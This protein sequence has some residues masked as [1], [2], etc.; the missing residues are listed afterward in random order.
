M[1]EKPSPLGD[2]YPL[3]LFPSAVRSAELEPVLDIPV[4]SK[5]IFL[6]LAETT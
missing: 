5:A 6:T 3:E 2:C 1:H 4:A